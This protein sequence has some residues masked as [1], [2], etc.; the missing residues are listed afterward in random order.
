MNSTVGDCSSGIESV[1]SS[2][3]DGGIFSSGDVLGSETVNP[4]RWAGA[5]DETGDKLS[6]GV[7]ESSEPKASEPTAQNT[8]VGDWF[9]CSEID[10]FGDEDLLG[11]PGFGLSLTCG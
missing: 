5:T 9:S 11:S 7:F 4:P 8:D 2:T 1:V 10:K 6:F 3:G